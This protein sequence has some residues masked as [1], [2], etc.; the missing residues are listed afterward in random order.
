MFLKN[1]V[2]RTVVC[3]SVLFLLLQSCDSTKDSSN[4]ETGKNLIVILG[5]STAYGI[6]PSSLGSSWA[7][8]LQYEKSAIVNNLSYPGYTTYQFLPSNEP[9][10]RGVT[11]DKERNIEAAIKLSPNIVIFSITTNDIANGYSIDEYL[12]NMKVMTDLCVKNK[13]EYIITSTTPRTPLTLDKR[14]ALYDLNRKL[15]VIYPER[16]VEI[17]NLLAD[18]NTYK[19]Q[20]NLCAS[21]SIHG[22]DKAHAIIYKEVL[23]GYEKAKTR[24]SK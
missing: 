22:N 12:N 23:A 10:L 9:N 4:V 7:G 21:D 6:G 18:L 3:L 24:L 11:P 15:E 20:T 14:K 2:V 13:I 1:K 8:L 19:W 17:Y 5:S 16:Y